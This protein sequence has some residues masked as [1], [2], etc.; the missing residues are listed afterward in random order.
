MRC[1]A[2]LRN[3]NQGQRGHP[4]TADIVAG[5]ADAGCHDAEKFGATIEPVMQRRKY[6][7]IGRW[8]Q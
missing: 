5:F 3:V 7:A 6:G 8:T 2:F 1:V 4:S